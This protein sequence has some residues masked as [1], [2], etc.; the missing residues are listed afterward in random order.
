MAESVETA[1]G[2]TVH[3][4]SK[5]IPTSSTCVFCKICS[6]EAPAD[7]VYEDSEYLCFV[8]RRPVSTHHYL[9]MPRQHIPDPKTLTANDIPVVERMT[10]I[11]KQVLGDREGNIDEARLGFHWPP[12]LLV[13]H[14]HL[15]I[16]SPE[17]RMS[18]FN[19]NIVFRK[20]SFAFSSPEYMYNY[21]TKKKN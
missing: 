8:D 2:E 11:G 20:D 17:G 16:I 5:P 14:L 18:W 4:S 12:F 21:L 3:A 15:H 9:V 19:R 7:I 1:G 10:E 13:K 6:K